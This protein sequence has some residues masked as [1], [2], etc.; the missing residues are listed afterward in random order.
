MT[1]D[2]CRCNEV[3]MPIRAVMPAVVFLLQQINTVPGI[4]CTVL[5]LEMLLLK[6][7]LIKI[8]SISLCVA[9]TQDTF[10]VLPHHLF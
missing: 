10:T 8:I 4:S 5:G 7:L 2:Y 3:V 1:T 9:G 6:S